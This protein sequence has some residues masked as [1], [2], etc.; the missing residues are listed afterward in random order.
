MQATTCSTSAT[1]RSQESD[2]FDLPGEAID[3]ALAIASGLKSDARL[4]D[5]HVP[6]RIAESQS[7]TRGELLHAPFSFR[8]EFRPVP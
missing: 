5:P 2:D 6:R 3:H 7:D 4:K 1:L 8:Q